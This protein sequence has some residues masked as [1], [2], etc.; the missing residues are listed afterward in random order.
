MISRKAIGIIAII[1]PFWFLAVYLIMAGLRPE[2]SYLTK[3]VSELGSVHAPHRWFW[4]VFGFITPGLAIALLGVGLK[5]EFSD[6]GPAARAPAFALIVSGLFVA[7]AGVFPGNFIDR[8]A[9]TMIMHTIGSFG[10]GLCFLIAGCWFPFAFRKHS[11]WRWLVW[12]SSG[13]V[14]GTLVGDFLVGV[15]RHTSPG[16]GQRVTF[17]CYFLWIGIAGY[18]LMRS[19]SLAPCKL[20]RSA[21][22]VSLP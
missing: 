15:M 10:S 21:P 14:L 13:L 19:A 3:A 7:L 4:N 18:A 9:L 12:P 5:S 1:T 16:L 17:A 22:E 2:Y 8:R 11:H 6:A 20:R